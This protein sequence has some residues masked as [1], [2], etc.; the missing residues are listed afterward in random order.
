MGAGI[1]NKTLNIVAQKTSPIQTK[2]KCEEKNF[3]SNHELQNKL[4]YSKMKYNTRNNKNNVRFDNIQ[5]LAKNQERINRNK[6]DPEE[7]NTVIEICKEVEIRMIFR[8]LL[9][10][11]ES[12][13]DQFVQDVLK[14]G[15]DKFSFKIFDEK[16][17]PFYGKVDKIVDNQDSDHPWQRYF[18]HLGAIEYLHYNAEDDFDEYAGKNEALQRELKP[19]YLNLRKNLRTKHKNMIKELMKSLDIEIVVEAKEKYELLWKTS[20][21]D[22]DTEND[23]DLLTLLGAI[24]FGRLSLVTHLGIKMNL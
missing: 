17:N 9:E 13:H 18:I 16:L 7:F 22:E 19:R 5:L 21:D 23:A 15:K 6:P 11:Y 24:H 8:K 1:V 2:I 12:Y 4:K 10:K 20:H 3:Y 14:Y